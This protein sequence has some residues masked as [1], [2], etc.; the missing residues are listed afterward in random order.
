MAIMPG[1][2]SAASQWRSYAFI[3]S[4][5]FL[6]GCGASPFGPGGPSPA[7]LSN[8]TPMHGP[9]VGP[10]Q[11]AKLADAYG[12]LPLSFEANRGQ[13]DRRVKFLSRG[14]SY[15]L[16]FTSDELV[17][18]LP[19]GNQSKDQSLAAWQ[20][21]EKNVSS[22][23]TDL[24]WMRLI[25]ANPDVRVSGLGEL[26]GKA[27]YFVGNERAKWQ[28]NVPTYAKLKYE[29]VYP[30]VDLIYYGNQRRLE[31]DFVVAP[32]ADPKAIRLSFRSAKSLA[33]D[34][35]GALVF[36][37]ER[38]GLRFE[39]PGIYQEVEGKRRAVQGQYVLKGGGT[40]GFEIGNYDRAKPLLI[41]P[42][43]VYSTYLGGSEFNQGSAIAVDS[44]G[45]AYVTGYTYSS[46]FPT[47]N[48]FQTSLAGVTDAFITKIDAS[49]SALVYSTYLGGPANLAASAGSAIAVDSSGN[50]YVTGSTSSGNFP[51][52]N[53]IQSSYGGGLDYGDAF[54]AEID[55]SGSALVYSTYLGGAGD[56]YGTGIAVDSSGNTY[57]AG[58]TASSNFPTASPLQA[59]FG[60]GV[61]FGD[62]FV[63]KISPGGS[64]LVYST[65]LG[66]S[67]EDLGSGIAVDSSGNA[68]VTGSTA[69]T[70]FPLM[71]ALQSTP[72]PPGISPS[73][74]VLNAF[75]TKI[76]ASGSA[77]V[78]S[79]YLGGSNSALAFGIAVDSSGDAYVTGYT[80]G[81]FPTVNAL[82]PNLSGVLAPDGF[83]AKINTA[84]SALIYSTYLGGSG[85][86][87]ALAI[88]VDSSGNAY[89]T[90]ETN[91]SDF[92]AIDPLQPCF[93]VA[94][95]GSLFDVFIAKISAPGSA[96]VYS[97]CLGGSGND[98]GF[99]IAVDSTGNAYVTGSTGS[100]N[101]PTVNPEQSADAGVGAFIAKLLPVI[102]LSPRTLVFAG[103][104]AGTASTAQTITLDNETNTISAISTL[105]I[106]GANGSDFAETDNCG[107][108]V[109]A[110]ASCRI[111]VVFAPKATGTRTGMLTVTYN[112]NSPSPQT[113]VLSGVG[114]DFSLAPSSQSAVTVTRGQ[115]GSLGLTVAPVSGFR[116]TVTFSCIGAPAQS[117]CTVSPGSIALNGMSAAAVT[118]TVATTAPSV[119]TPDSL[120]RTPPLNPA[121]WFLFAG[122]LGWAVA[123]MTPRRCPRLLYGGALILFVCASLMVGCGSSSGTSGASGASGSGSSSSGNPG[124]PTGNYTLT[125]TGTSG[126]GSATFSHSTNLTLIVQ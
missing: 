18:A 49:G 99:G 4:S 114:Q 33:V 47:V 92:P 20:Y 85:N 26:P 104:P 73:G 109:A 78:Y 79:T 34:E 37:T 81:D 106:G 119:A 28:T 16:Y 74:L 61:N 76:D 72:P 42:V 88:A 95:G 7:A 98:I 82:Q 96:L 23:R 112:A 77:L 59:S 13:S 84:G 120:R 93:G 116:Q 27:N 63:S 44:S 75:V 113:V 126:T 55:A 21:P 64:T 83:V 38:A 67:S 103:Q 31:Y 94:L 56:D 111:Q 100:T 122:L 11:A 58:T 90:G 117:T 108:G 39:R 43:L 69:S 110:A 60:G 65:Y 66:G 125:V 80:I 15:A 101:F 10:S 8:G 48:A 19:N 124:T 17:V 115:S 87:A 6:S 41:D 89:V 24:L 2:K 22:G 36:G 62:A 35:R 5:I 91:S 57:V 52:V 29:A 3:V 12:K 1:L 45:N 68:Y 32:G 86:D 105:G 40:V 107:G 102:D 53:A 30:G 54:A 50:A 97:T 25:G 9:T 71:N 118:V 51:L 70:N 14:S 123:T 121:Y 46:N